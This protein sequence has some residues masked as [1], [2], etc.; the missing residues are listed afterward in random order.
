M[1]PGRLPFAVVPMHN[2]PQ[3]VSKHTPLLGGAGRFLLTN[4][5]MAPSNP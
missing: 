4:W 3:L 1:A 5:N 2:P